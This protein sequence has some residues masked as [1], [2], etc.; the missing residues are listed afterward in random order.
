MP[1]SPRSSAPL[2]LCFIRNMPQ[3][4]V[5]WLVNLPT[6]GIS[7]TQQSCPGCMSGPS[8]LSSEPL[9]YASEDPTAASWD[10]VFLM[11]QALGSAI[12]CRFSL[13]LLIHALLLYCIQQEVDQPPSFHCI[14]IYVQC[15][16][17]YIV[18][19]VSTK[20]IERIV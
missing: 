15:V 3:T 17:I 13:K 4:S 2:M 1:H 16:C 19:L 12:D 8:S 10:S 6:N 9:I 14:Y 11:E 20:N 5:A 18:Y 7:P